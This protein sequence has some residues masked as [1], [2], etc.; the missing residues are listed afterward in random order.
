MTTPR[1]MT[2]HPDPEISALGFTS[3]RVRFDNGRS[4]H[5]WYPLGETPK[6][7]RIL[8]RAGESSS[9]RREQ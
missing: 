9:V 6:R 7:A 4:R 8:V 5:A 1:R 2:A 3:A